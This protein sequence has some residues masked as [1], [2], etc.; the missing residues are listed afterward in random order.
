MSAGHAPAVAKRVA[1]AASALLAAAVMPAAPAAAE[2]V[3]GMRV[4]SI[5]PYSITEDTSEPLGPPVVIRVDISDQTMHV[6]VGENLTYTFKVSTGRGG[7]GTPVG[8]YK[9][10]WIAAKWRSRK[11]N[12][13]PMPWSVFFHGGYAI[14]GTTDLKRLGRPASHGCVRLH[15]DNAKLIYSLVRKNGRD[16][17]LITIVR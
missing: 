11:Y 17:T 15:P 4:A 2:I 1:I 12:N 9:A 7:Y 8:R 6:Y 16:N 3:E 13:A 5:V 14:H 10:E